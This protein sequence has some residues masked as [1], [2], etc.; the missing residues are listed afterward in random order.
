MLQCLP[1]SPLPAER[2]SCQPKFAGINLSSTMKAR[3]ECPGDFVTDLC[4]SEAQTEA[5]LS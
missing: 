3:N 1:L 4:S 5:P 2:L